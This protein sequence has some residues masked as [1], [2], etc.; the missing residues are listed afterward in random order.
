MTLWPVLLAVIAAHT[1]HPPKQRAELVCHASPRMGF[2]DI[3]THGLQVTLRCELTGDEQEDLYCP[4]VVWEMPDGTVSEQEADCP[5]YRCGRLE[6]CKD[7]EEPGPYERHWT[8]RVMADGGYWQ[9][10]VRL[11]H[12]KT[13]LRA[14]AVDFEVH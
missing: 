7:V 12:G 9:V 6:L 2:A 13:T 5:P 10:R 11:M 1:P 3:A 8:K 4:K 14:A